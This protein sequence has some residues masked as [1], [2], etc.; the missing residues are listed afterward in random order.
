M[1]CS[2][3]YVAGVLTIVGSTASVLYVRQQ[4]PPPDTICP[5]LPSWHSLTESVFR[6][7]VPEIHESQP[8]ILQSESSQ[9]GQINSADSKESRP[10]GNETE[11]TTTS[12]NKSQNT[13]LRKNSR[14]HSS[15][16]FPGLLTLVMLKDTVLQFVAGVHSKYSTGGHSKNEQMDS[17]DLHG[18]DLDLSRNDLDLE[19]TTVVESA[20]DD[21]LSG[22][23]CSC[24]CCGPTSGYDKLCYNLTSP[25]ANNKQGHAHGRWN[26]IK[27][28]LRSGQGHM[29]SDMDYTTTNCF[30]DFACQCCC[31]VTPTREWVPRSHDSSDLLR[32]TLSFHRIEEPFAGMTFGFGTSPSMAAA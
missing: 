31:A 5:P 15:L 4:L 1:V 8:E 7:S 6:A 28:K 24:G 18:N 30:P 27:P 14:Q 16:Q 13:K 25:F 26:S 29:N 22:V 2:V 21:S 11:A 9:V 32:S 19:P 3:A 12:S 17:T 23:I 20:D 10:H